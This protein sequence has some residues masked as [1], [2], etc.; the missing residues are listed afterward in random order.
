MQ[1]MALFASEFFFLFD[2]FAAP[3]P[4]C[5]HRAVFITVSAVQ[6]MFLLD[7]IRLSLHNALLRTATLTFSAPNTAIDDNISFFR[8]RSCSKRI[9]FTKNRLYAKVEIFYLCVLY[10]ENNPDFS[11]IT[12]INI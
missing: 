5:T 9:T 8:K 12:R 3:F 11:G 2:S 6:T 4:D 7:K 1:A 10:L